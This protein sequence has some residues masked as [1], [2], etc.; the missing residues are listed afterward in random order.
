MRTMKKKQESKQKSKQTKGTNQS[1]LPNLADDFLNGTMV[2]KGISDSLPD[3]QML[4]RSNKIEAD[5]PRDIHD[6]FVREVRVNYAATSQVSFVIDGPSSVAELV[7][8]ILT[9]N[10][11]EHCVAL[12]LSSAN[13]VVCFSLIS[14]GTANSAPLTPREVFQRAI[15]V[16]SIHVI[17]SHTHP[18]GCVTPSE[19]DYIITEQMRAA[20][21]IIGISVVD[22]VIVSDANFYSMREDPMW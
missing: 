1:L 15:L 4:C 22:H 13:K 17:L 5:K 12:Y 11:R 18:S 6:T 21:E 7:R 9:D 10:S 2:V 14:I 16:G 8:T 19:T 20:G 3:D